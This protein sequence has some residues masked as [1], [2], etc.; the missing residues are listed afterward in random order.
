MARAERVILDL[1][2]GD[3]RAVVARARA[4]PASLVLGIDADA[5]AMAEASRR[6]ARR[7]ERGGLPNAAFLADAAERMPGPLAGI[8]SLVTITF[9]WGSLLAGVLGREPAVAAGIAGLVRP[10]G[11]VE[12]LVS[13]EPGDRIDGLERLTAD[14]EARLAAGWA[15]SGLRLICHR[16][17][18][19]DEVLA[20]GSTWGRRLLRGGRGT[21]TTRRTVWRLELER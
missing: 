7:V 17:A 5:R 2:T 10:G 16:L 1:G 9:P 13:V 21:M 20:S 4:E 15:S 6:A 12:I 18:T 14:D 3:G 8:A 11:R 19:T